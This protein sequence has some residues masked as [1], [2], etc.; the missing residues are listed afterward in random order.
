MSTKQPEEMNK[1][2]LAR[3][4]NNELRSFVEKEQAEP[5]MRWWLRWRTEVGWRRMSKLLT[6]YSKEFQIPYVKEEEI[7]NDR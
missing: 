3:I 7:E 2:R 6:V 5:F 1:D 4:A